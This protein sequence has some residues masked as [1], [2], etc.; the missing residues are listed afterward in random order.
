MSHLLPVAEIRTHNWAS[1]YYHVVFL[2]NIHVMINQRETRTRLGKTILLGKFMGKLHCS[3]I[4]CG[5]S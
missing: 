2:N 1:V 5:I 4:Q 3:N